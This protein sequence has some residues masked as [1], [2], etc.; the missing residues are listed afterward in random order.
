MEDA[1]IV[2]IVFYTTY[3]LLELCLLHKER[4]LMFLKMNE[5]SPEMMQ[6]KLSSLQSVQKNKFQNN[7]FFMLRLGAVALSIG[8]GWIFA[9]ILYEVHRNLTGRY[10]DWDSACLATISFCVGIALIIVYLIE[11]KAFKESKKRE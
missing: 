6:S 3:K 9:S 5:L 4:K 2:G 7:P 1:L 11:R 8:L 10:F